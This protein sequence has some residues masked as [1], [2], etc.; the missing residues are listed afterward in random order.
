MK[1]IKDKTLWCIGSDRLISQKEH[2]GVN[3]YDGFMYSDCGHIILGV[4]NMEHGE[5]SPLYTH[6]SDNTMVDVKYTVG[7]LKKFGK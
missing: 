7:L 5:H 6:L 3:C 1:K 4:S 2:Y